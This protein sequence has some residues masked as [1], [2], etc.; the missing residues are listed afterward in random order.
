M[1]INVCHYITLTKK[2]FKKKKDNS[3][4]IIS[5]VN[6]YNIPG[7]ID[8]FPRD[9]YKT[10]QYNENIEKIIN[11]L[12]KD[13]NKI[14]VKYFDFNRSPNLKDIISSKYKNIYFITS[15]KKKM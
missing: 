8:S 10:E 14:S 11:G 2:R 6:Y 3:G 9:I 15:K 12:H 5:A 4:I 13:I 1:M 7:R